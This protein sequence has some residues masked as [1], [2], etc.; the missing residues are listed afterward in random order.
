LFSM[1][2]VLF[3]SQGRLSLEFPILYNDYT[4]ILWNI[5]DYATISMNSLNLFELLFHFYV[6]IV[7]HTEPSADQLT[8]KRL[9]YLICSWIVKYLY[10]LLLSIFLIQNVSYQLTNCSISHSFV[11]Y[12]LF[13]M[14]FLNIPLFYLVFLN[15]SFIVACY[16]E[17]SRKS[18]SKIRS[19]ANQKEDKLLLESNSRFHQN[20]KETSSE[21]NTGEQFRFF[22]LKYQTFMIV[23]FVNIVWLTTL[24]IYRPLNFNK[25]IQFVYFFTYLLSNMNPLFILYFSAEYYQEFRSLLF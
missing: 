18:A 12:M 11:Y 15:M 25:F 7:N 20:L 17:K 10:S 1:V 13:D 9:I 16:F 2:T 23:L 19:E 4:C 22:I 8:K 6:K 24:F 14:K 21:N 3:W 5:N